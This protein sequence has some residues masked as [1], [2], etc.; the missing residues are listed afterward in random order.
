MT[1]APQSIASS[2][3]AGAVRASVL[4]GLLALSLLLTG[5]SGL[6]YQ[7]VWFRVLGLVFGVTVH[8]TSAVLAAFMAGLAIGSLLAARVTDRIKNPLLAYGVVEVAIGALGL[9]S[10][11]ALGLLQPIYRSLALQLPESVLLVTSVRF[12][13]AFAI[14][15][16]PTT[17]MGVTLP[18]V[19]RAVVQRAGSLSGAV[20]FLYG[21]NT[22][23]AIAGAFLAGFVFLGSFG[24]PA[25]V[26]IAAAFNLIVGLLWIALALGPLRPALEI[27]EEVVRAA[28][29][30][31]PGFRVSPTVA[32]TVLVA[33]GLSGFVA[34]AYEVV[35]TRVL[36]GILPSTVYA[37]TLMLCAIL[38]GIAVG[39][40]AI[41]PLLKRRLNWVG[42]FVALEIAI[43]AL[44]LLSLAFMAQATRIEAFLLRG[45]PE[46]AFLLGRPQFMI[47]FTLV[48]I[49]PVA[50]MMGV[51][52]PVAA[53]LYAAGQTDVGRR[54]GS[55]YGANVLG[56]VSGSLAA[57]LVLIPVLGAQ[58][59][60][61][62]L[63][64]GNVVAGLAVLLAARPPLR[65]T[66]SF[67]AVGA[68]VLLIAAVASPNLYVALSEG[69][70]RGLRT[71]WL[72][73][74]QDATVSV[75]RAPDERRYLKINSQG[76]GSDGGPQAR[77]HQRLGHLGPL[78]HPN[79]RELLIIGLGVGATA[80]AS[81]L[82]PGLNVTIVELVPAVVDAA[83]LFRAANF[84]VLR[85]PNTTVRVDDGRN[86]LLLTDRTFD[87]IESDPILPRNAG[88]ANLYSADFYRLVRGALNPDGIFVQ[89]VDP[90]LPPAAHKMMVRTF[91]SEFPGAT[92][93]ENGAILVGSREPIRVP[94]ERLRARLQHS[95]VADALAAVGLKT[96]EDVLRGY[97]GGPRE[98]AFY[99]G[100]GPIMTDAHPYIEYY[101]SLP[102]GGTVP[103][104]RWL[105]AA[106]HLAA[107]ARPGDS[108]VYGQPAFK[109]VL[110]ELPIPALPDFV[111]PAEGV[112]DGA[113][114]AALRD[115]AAKG[116]VWFVP[117]PGNARDEQ[118]IALL[119][120]LKRLAED[121]QHGLVRVLL[122]E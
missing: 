43:A 121:R 100:A 48:A 45:A 70:A 63:S 54:I 44:A 77:F 56:A 96:A 84:D 115:L 113:T 42:V 101:L 4:A 72:H 31:A 60:L 116:R 29:A 46:G 110:N 73:E 25:T 61:W 74:G 64:L 19:V 47:P 12:A 40:W 71:I 28:T 95:A 41:N 62:L 83:E 91:L 76:M 6:I 105:P 118:A 9:L 98:L 7:V 78:I 5:A 80:G 85:R 69:E 11:P 66:L 18:L 86:Y 114:E 94:S 119:S 22:F 2:V 120:R 59:A 55:V 10:L 32:T 82:H 23:G 79:P 75:V 89:W 26:G 57:G 51:T 106:T 39:S 90:T 3:V 21:A 111:L 53:M 112:W 92:M 50:F 27:D 8:A 38:S 65:T 20:S 104:L 109:A 16:L 36:A 107:S 34:L 88:A 99:A 35:W 93:W 1:T 117:T 108:L 13:L 17:L 15:L 33:Y 37:F 68:A 122:F 58:R 81:A 97:V 30:G 67:G 24:V 14:M 52:F 49:F 87:I 103:D 102:G